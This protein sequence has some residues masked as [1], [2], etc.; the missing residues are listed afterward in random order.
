MYG[1]DTSGNA[2]I[3][4]TLVFNAFV[5]AQISNSVNLRRLDW[6]LNIFE[7]MLNNWYFIAILQ[8]NLPDMS[9]RAIMWS[10][11]TTFPNV[12]KEEKLELLLHILSKFFAVPIFFQMTKVMDIME[13]FLKM[14]GWKYLCFDGGTK[15]EE[16][17]L[18]IQQ[19]NAKDSVSILLTQAG[20]LG[21]NL[22]TADTVII[23]PTIFSILSQHIHACYKLDIN[24]EMVIQSNPQSIANGQVPGHQSKLSVMCTIQAG[25]I[26]LY[27]LNKQ[28]D[29]IHSMIITLHLSNTDSDTILLGP[30]PPHPLPEPQQRFYPF[31]IRLH[32]LCNRLSTNHQI[33]PYLN[34]V[35][36]AFAAS[37]SNNIFEA[38]N[39]PDRQSAITGT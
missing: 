23:Q 14:M 22:R 26:L 38:I 8:N 16:H 6:K 28:D 7:G 34:I 33:G 15:M 11:Q 5:F 25:C 4:Q 1:I 29:T 31:F 9:R 18:H 37:A 3:V 36:L 17:A 13:D 19:F 30:E 39:C 35:P 32:S 2:T 21:L 24:N 10:A 20:G 27:S 12:N